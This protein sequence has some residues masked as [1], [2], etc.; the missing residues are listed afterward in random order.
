MTFFLR[1]LA[2]SIA[3]FLVRTISDSLRGEEIDQWSYYTG[4]IAA[5]A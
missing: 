4:I 3:V 2:G 5:F 1:V